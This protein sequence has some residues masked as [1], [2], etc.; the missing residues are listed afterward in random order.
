M[1]KSKPD[2][3]NRNPFASYGKYSAMAFQMGLLIAA[4]V[5][6]GYQIDHWIKLRFPVFTI[7]LSLAAVAGAIWLLIKELNN[8]KNDE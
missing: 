7:V 6:G 1:L 2:S 5:L 4:G 3:P 8:S